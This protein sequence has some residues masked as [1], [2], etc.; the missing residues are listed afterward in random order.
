MPSPM[1]GASDRMRISSAG[2]VMVEG[3]SGDRT[4]NSGNGPLWQ[5]GTGLQSYGPAMVS[6]HS[7]NPDLALRAQRK[8]VMAGPVP[9]IHVLPC[10][11]LKRRGCPRRARHGD[12]ER[13][14]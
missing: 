4:G 10:Y 13:G 9:A 3:L 5:A 1:V 11:I 14:N 6:C 2:W 12:V 8:V 7:R